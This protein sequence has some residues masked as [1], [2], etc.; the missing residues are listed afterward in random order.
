MNFDILTFLQIITKTGWGSGAMS[1]LAE[2]GYS[3][4]WARNIKNNIGAELSKRNEGIIICCYVSST[5]YVGGG[6]LLPDSCCWFRC[7]PLTF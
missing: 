3:E 1:I 5:T 4:L 2:S 7:A 6:A